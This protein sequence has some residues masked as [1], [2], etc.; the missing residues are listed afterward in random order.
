M[1][2]QLREPRYGSMV[3]FMAGLTGFLVLAAALRQ[4]FEPS[5]EIW[6]SAALVVML[7]LYAHLGFALGR[8]RQELNMLKRLTERVQEDPSESARQ[9]APALRLEEATGLSPEDKA[10]L[11]RVSSAIESDRLELYLQPIVSLPQRKA[12]F[13]EAFS[14]IRDDKGGVLKPVDYID[15]AERANRIGVIDNMILLRCVQA[16]R[17]LRGGGV[18]SVFCN[19]SPAT[20]YDTEFFE[21]FTEYLES[22]SDL[23]SRLVFEFTSPAVQMMHPRVEENLAAIAEKGFPFSIDHVTSLNLDWQS[24]RDR[25]FRYVKAPSAL[26]LNASRKDEASITQLRNFRKRLAEAEIDL[27]AEKI[28]RESDMPEILEL[29]IDFGQGNLFGAPRRSDF[30]LGPDAAPEPVLAEAS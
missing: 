29:G 26:L 8:A 10:M 3:L 6:L 15:A 28:E 24:L 1:K 17:E 2:L 13:Y 20:L 12:R 22:N 9:I 7:L 16:L 23:A 5:L 14:R 19:I 4:G 18:S 27:I 21:H 25:N 11:E 30:Y